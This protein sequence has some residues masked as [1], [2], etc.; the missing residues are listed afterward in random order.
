MLKRFL[1]MALPS[2][3]E[4]EGMLFP[5]L[6]RTGNEQGLLRSNWSTWKK[7]R[8]MRGKTSRTYD[9]SIALEVVSG[10][11]DFIEEC[12]FLLHQLSIRIN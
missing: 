12:V 5:D 10:I 6:I 7:Y 2:S 1:E 9:E 11:P 8:E 4:L 3:E